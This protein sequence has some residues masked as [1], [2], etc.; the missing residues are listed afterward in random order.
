MYLK[1]FYKMPEG[2]EKE[3]DKKGVCTNQP[4]IDY[5]SLY[6]TGVDVNQNFSIDLVTD[7]L[8]N[9]WATLKGDKLTLLVC[10]ENLKYK[11][12]RE[13]GRYCCHCGE[14]L[15]DDD[16][17]SMARLHIANKHPDKE[18][19]DPKNTSGYCK[20]NYF[21]CV[22][23]AKQHDKYRV[24]EPTKAPHFPMRSDSTLEVS[25]DA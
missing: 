21:E 20:I 13:P 23:D 17:G 1:R 15:Q 10:P 11:I 19:P 6:H 2:W 9:K 22:L 25:P 4:P 3:V 5:V 16:K 7:A 18:S 24:K 8:K 12:L 14:K